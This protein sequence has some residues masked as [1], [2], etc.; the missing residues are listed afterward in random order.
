M[1]SFRA[2][3][4]EIMFRSN[5]TAGR[6]FDIALLVMIFLSISCVLLESVQSYR[7]SYGTLF[8]LLEW[9]FT[10]FFSVEYLLRLYSA[11]SARRYAFSF[12]GILDFVATIP[13]YLALIFTGSSS[14]LVIRAIRLLRVFRILKL[15]RYFREGVV[16]R[17]ALL[18]SRR[19]VIVFLFGVIC[20]VL[21][22]GTIMYLIEGETNGF[23]S[24]P[25]G[26]YWAIVTV[27]TVGYGDVVPQT[28]LG[29][30]IASFAMI[31]GYAIIAVP[32]GILTS[33]LT[34]IRRKEAA[35]ICPNCPNAKHE[36]KARFCWNCGEKI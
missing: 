28:H 16:L 13:S 31:L 25:M 27:T 36:V 11:K 19:K 15:G 12:Y 32:T 34:E 4:Y 30:T 14:L 20:L 8:I 22:M 23:T 35:S 10:F 33:E 3:V 7:A 17:E 5:T 24:I 6:A 26:I 21:L 18:A 2:K 9:L 29:R 1:Q